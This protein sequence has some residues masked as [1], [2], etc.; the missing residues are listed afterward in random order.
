M[1]RLIY[2]EKLSPKTIAAKW[3]QPVSEVTKQSRNALRSLYNSDFSNILLYGIHSTDK[4]A[5]EKAYN[6]GY[7]KGYIDGYKDGRNDLKK[8]KDFKTRQE[9]SVIKE[10]NELPQILIEDL[11]LPIQ[12]EHSFRFHNIRTLR[13]IAAL[14]LRNYLICD[15]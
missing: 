3:D 14:S 15:L 10:L 9:N 4:S 7:D 12:V 13:D 2:N 1:L 6:E 5:Y 8:D 11:N